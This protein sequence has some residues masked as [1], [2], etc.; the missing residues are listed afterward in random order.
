[1]NPPLNIVK[2][3]E[4]YIPINSISKRLWINIHKFPGIFLQMF[5]SINVRLNTRFNHSYLTI[6]M[7]A[8]PA[9]FEIIND[10]SNLKVKDKSFRLSK[11]RGYI[12]IFPKLQFYFFIHKNFGERNVMSLHIR[13]SLF[14]KG[15]A[16]RM[17]IYIHVWGWGWGI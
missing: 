15:G 4:K 10:A 6:M 5:I 9:G 11:Y 1:M 2:S 17:Q 3:L 16:G 8:C 14:K 12:C 13:S 7:Y